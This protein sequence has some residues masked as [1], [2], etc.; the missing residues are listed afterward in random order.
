MPPG[1][2]R[3]KFESAAGNTCRLVRV[4]SCWVPVTPEF[5]W[6]SNG[7]S[8]PSGPV[9]SSEGVTG[10]PGGRTRVARPRETRVLTAAGDTRLWL[11]YAKNE[12]TARTAGSLVM[13]GSA[14]R[15][16]ASA[17]HFWAEESDQSPHPVCTYSMGALAL[18][19]RSIDTIHYRSP[20]DLRSA[21][22]ATVS[23][24]TLSQTPAMREVARLRCIR[25][26]VATTASDHPTL[27]PS[28]AG[29]STSSESL[30][31][32]YSH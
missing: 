3:R 5:R 18:R 27:P 15:V 13:K 26:V 19:L 32:S 10:L 28:T 22:N 12:S 25:G 9:T 14:V 1:V 29:S 7:G 21:I 4:M 11:S 16:R 31:I 20:S 17:S 24:P 6:V 8:S 30:R 23:R 2:P